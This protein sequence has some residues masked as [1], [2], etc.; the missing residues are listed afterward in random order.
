MYHNDGGNGIL[1][2]VSTCLIR[3]HGVTS[4]KRAGNCLDKRPYAVPQQMTMYQRQK[5]ATE[6]ERLEVNSSVS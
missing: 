4:N 6:V 5:Y 2:N 1:G 3:L